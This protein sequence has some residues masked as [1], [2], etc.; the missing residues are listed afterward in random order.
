MAFRDHWGNVE[1]TEEDY[2]KFVEGTRQG[3]ARRCWQVAWS[4][5]D[6]VGQVRTFANDGDREMFGRRRAWTEHISTARAWRKRGIAT[7]VV[8]ASLRQLAELGYEEAA[9]GVD[10]QNPSGALGLYESL[11]Y[12]VVA[13]D[14]MLHRR[15]RLAILGMARAPAHSVMTE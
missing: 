3:R 2:L 4:G 7:A 10:T 8:C 13:T 11:G 1:Q 12:E 6:V 5:D 15:S 9:L 14:V